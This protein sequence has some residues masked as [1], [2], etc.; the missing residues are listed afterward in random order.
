MKRENELICVQHV[1]FNLWFD[2]IKIPVAMATKV[3]YFT[4]GGIE[5]QA[6]FRSDDPS[7]EIK[8]KLS[9]L[10]KSNTN[11]GSVNL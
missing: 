1:D 7:E 2:S 3:I 11:Y 4:V 10:H 8:G 9:Q 6:E 5:E